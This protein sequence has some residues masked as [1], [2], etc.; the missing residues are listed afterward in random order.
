MQRMGEKMKISKQ[1][2]IVRIIIIILICIMGV[3]SFIAVERV[4]HNAETFHQH[5]FITRGSLDKIESDTLNARLFMEE[6][7]FKNDKS[8]IKSNTATIDEYEPDI[9]KQIDMLQNSYLGPE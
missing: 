1:L 4:W 3:F 7:V 6:V 9:Q 8:S 2:N 5:P